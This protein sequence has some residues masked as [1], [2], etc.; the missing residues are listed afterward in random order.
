[1]RVLEDGEFFSLEEQTYV[2]WFEAGM[3][4][5]IAQVSCQVSCDPQAENQSRRNKL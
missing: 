2:C 4:S 1:M 5:G 3:P